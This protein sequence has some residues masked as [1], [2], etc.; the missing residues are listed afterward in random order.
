MYTR[1]YP[2]L[3]PP[4]YRTKMGESIPPLLKSSD[5]RRGW[6]GEENL[7]RPERGAVHPVT[8]SLHGPVQ[9]LSRLV[10]SFLFIPLRARLERLLPLPWE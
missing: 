7:T 8:P 2:L 10:K 6:E 5:F 1:L 3:P 4:F 9:F